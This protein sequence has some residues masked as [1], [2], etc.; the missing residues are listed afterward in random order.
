MAKYLSPA[1]D[2]ETRRARYFWAPALSALS[3]LRRSLQ[4]STFLLLSSPLFP[5]VPP[6]SSCRKPVRTRS[7]TPSLYCPQLFVAPSVPRKKVQLLRPSP[8]TLLPVDTKQSL[9]FPS[10]PGP[11]APLSLCNRATPPLRPAPAPRHAGAQTRGPRPREPP[12]P[13]S[14]TWAA[15]TRPGAPRSGLEGLGGGGRRGPGGRAFTSAGSLRAA[16]AIGLC[17]R[18]AAVGRGDLDPRPLRVT[19]RPPP[20]RLRAAS[21]QP[22]ERLP[23]LTGRRPSSPEPL[24]EQTRRKPK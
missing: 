3:P 4:N 1:Q 11:A 14:G 6:V 2:P 17:R 15:G 18:S 10:A 22:G 8:H 20:P 5:S 7:R 13:D 23:C 16:A 9:G 19:P 21:L 24:S 12:G